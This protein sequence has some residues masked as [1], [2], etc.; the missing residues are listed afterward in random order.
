MTSGMMPTATMSGGGALF[1]GAAARVNAG[2]GMGV[3]I[4]GGLVVALMA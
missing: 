4:V 3:G 2:V 1:T